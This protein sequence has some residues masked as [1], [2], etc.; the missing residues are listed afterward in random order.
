MPRTLPQYRKRPVDLA[1]KRMRI[2]DAPGVGVTVHV[3]T[4]KNVFLPEV[5]L[6]MKPLL[7][8]ARGMGTLIRRRVRDQGRSAVGAFSPYPGRKKRKT[9]APGKR[10]NTH[11]YEQ[12]DPYWAPSHYP[13]GANRTQLSHP[14]SAGKRVPLTSEKHPG[15]RAYPSRLE[16]QIA[17]AKR[18]QKRFK[19]MGEFWTGLRVRP[20][21]AG[22]VKVAFFGSSYK[23]HMRRK[24]LSNRKKASGMNKHERVSILQ[25][26]QKEME[27]AR[28]YCRLYVT[29]AFLNSQGAQ[30][31]R[32]KV[33]RS[34][35]RIERTI[36]ALAKRMKIGGF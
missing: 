19:I 33:L 12:L 17:I 21:R 28:R 16:Y 26:N 3:K 24:K 14:T 20:V 15:A 22:Y 29:S 13:Q 23:N 11:L 36:Q 30:E 8:L 9:A 2:K 10:K 7:D 34:G 5:L 4:I 27:W 6:D 31:L 35:A 32:I 25:P 1:A 18:P